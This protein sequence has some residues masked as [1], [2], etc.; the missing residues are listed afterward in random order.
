MAS[1]LHKIPLD[2]VLNTQLKLQDPFVHLRR[3]PIVLVQFQ[4]GNQ[5]TCKRRKHIHNYDYD[6]NDSGDDD[7]NDGLD[8]RN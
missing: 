1:F 2:A 8:V 4:H 7:D 3:H 5:A 6:E